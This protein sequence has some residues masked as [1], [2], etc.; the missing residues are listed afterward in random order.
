MSLLIAALALYGLMTAAHLVRKIM[1][2]SILESMVILAFLG[3]GYGE[4]R[5]APILDAA[6][7]VPVDPVPQALMLTA[8][9]IGVCFNCLALAF[10][11]KI[12]QHHGTLDV[13]R[14]HEP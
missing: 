10:I 4:Q 3:V 11:V 5:V 1:C 6:G 2:L 7:G 8:I 9:V 12:H 14:L 13:T